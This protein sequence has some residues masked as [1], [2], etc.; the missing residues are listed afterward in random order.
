MDG[1]SATARVIACWGLWPDLLWCRCRCTLAYRLTTHLS[2]FTFFATT[3][4]ESACPLERAFHGQRL[5][6]LVHINHSSIKL[7]GSSDPVQL[8]LSPKHACLLSSLPLHLFQESTCICLTF[9]PSP[10]GAVGFASRPLEAAPFL[11]A[12]APPFLSDTDSLSHFVCGPLPL[13]ELLPLH[14]AKR[15]V[16]FTFS[17]HV[18]HGRGK[19]MAVRKCVPHEE[20]C[21]CGLGLKSPE[22]APCYLRVKRIHPSQ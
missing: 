3:V 6:H 4:T 9:I 20:L 18:L 21:L 14:V 12:D 22:A 10:F 19:V 1:F 5:D 13:A 16:G 2:T 15:R 7:R 11:L 8:G 17:C